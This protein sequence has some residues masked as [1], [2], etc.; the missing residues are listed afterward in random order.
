MVKLAIFLQLCGWLGGW[1]PW[2]GAVSDTDYFEKSGLLNKQQEFMV[3]D[4]TSDLPFTNILDKG[5][6]STLAA[7]RAG[8]QLLLQPFFARSDRKLQSATVATDQA[9]NERAVNRLKECG[10]VT[11]GIHQ[12]ESLEEYADC[13]LAWGFESNF[14]Y[15]PVL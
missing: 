3:A 13:C 4:I 12:R 9:V 8:G 7:W 11:R 5:Y 14:V 15:K 10:T 2:L 1:D 6:R